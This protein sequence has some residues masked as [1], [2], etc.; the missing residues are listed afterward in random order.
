MKILITFVLILL[1]VGA[2]LCSAID[3]HKLHSEKFPHAATMTLRAP[4]INAK[5]NLTTED[6]KVEAGNVLGFDLYLPY[7]TTTFSCLALNNYQFMITR[8]WHSYGAPDFSAAINLNNGLVAGINYRDI[9]FFPCVTP[10]STAFAGEQLRRAVQVTPTETWGTLWFDIEVNPS[11][12]CG[13]S[14]TNFTA[15]CNFM[16][17][18]IMEAQQLS[19]Q[20]GL[21]SSHYEHVK[22]FGSADACPVA[23]QNGLPLWYANFDNQQTFADFQNFGGYSLNGGGDGKGR[24]AMKQFSDTTSV[25]NVIA[26]QNFYPS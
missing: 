24:V 6:K 25:C 7:P 12:N 18:L 2:L 23:Y 13:W 19:L 1:I 17:A 3:A 14:A 21:Y 15:N 22:L 20:V 8:A 9:Y 11:Q 4:K 26:D 16:T 5:H 10:N